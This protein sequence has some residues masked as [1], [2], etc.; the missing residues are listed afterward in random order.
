[1][2]RAKN[3]FCG[4]G[5]VA[6]FAA[7]FALS[8]SCAS[9]KN[10]GSLKEG[11]VEA[12]VLPSRTA[13]SW[14]D[15][16]IFL[17]SS[18]PSPSRILKLVPKKADDEEQKIYFAIS[19]PNDTKILKMEKKNGVS[20]KAEVDENLVTAS[21]LEGKSLISEE[22]A[23]RAVEF[24]NQ[25]EQ[26]FRQ[27]RSREGILNKFEIDKIIKKSDSIRVPS[28]DVYNGYS[29]DKYYEYKTVEWD[30]KRR[31]FFIQHS[32]AY[33]KDEIIYSANGSENFLITL[34]N[35]LALRDALSK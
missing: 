14:E 30:E 12:S 31:V 5:G 35:A 11:G 17:V 27:E 10:T 16:D 23:K 15:Y 6:I 32:T 21:E 7:Y 2:I 29:Y 19:S 13:N 8:L 9:S 28:K 1:M 20:T 25:L 34:E 18:N 3:V 22:D 24:I 33:G 4:V 26:N